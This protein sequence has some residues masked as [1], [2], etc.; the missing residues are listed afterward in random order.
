MADWAGAFA[1]TAGSVDAL[2]EAFQAEQDDYSAILA[3][4]VADRLAEALAEYDAPAR[5]A[6]AVGVRAPRGAVRTTT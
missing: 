4:A 6:R 3:K 5:A 2:V 1:V